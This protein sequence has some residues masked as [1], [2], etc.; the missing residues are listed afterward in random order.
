MN[1]GSKIGTWL[2]MEDLKREPGTTDVYPLPDT[3]AARIDFLNWSATLPED[4]PARPGAA[5]VADSA[6]VE[7]AVPGPSRPDANSHEPPDMD[8]KSLLF[9]SLLLPLGSC[10]MLGS[11]PRA[12]LLDPAHP[13]MNVQAPDSY[14][15]RFE[16]TKGPFV[17]EVV[18]EWAPNGADRFFNLVRH[19]YYDG[20]HFFRVVAGFVVQ[21]GLAAD[22]ALSTVWRSQ[23]MQD[24]PPRES[25]RRGYVTFATAGPNTRTAQVFINLADNSPLDRQ[26]FAPFARIVEGMEVVD[27]LYSGYGDGVGFTPGPDQSRIEA[28]G[29][30]YL[31][32]EF[33]LLDEIVSARLVDR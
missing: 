5:S 6:S 25:N 22:P 2:G 32:Q 8:L 30:A 26:G 11:N 16:T 19:G 17:M 18:R 33:P 28:E 27:S 12:V 3:V 23:R 7:H 15:V 1:S 10:A 14:Q 20:A 29:S 4:G 13:A 21:F 31:D 24:D 9:A